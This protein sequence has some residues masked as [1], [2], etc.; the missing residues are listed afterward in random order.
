MNKAA[1]FA[2]NVLKL[3]IIMLIQSLLTQ[4]QR[5]ASAYSREQIFQVIR[6]LINFLQER[7][8]TTI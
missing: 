4:S 5:E 8:Q 3:G 2:A 6:R 1:Q 7:K